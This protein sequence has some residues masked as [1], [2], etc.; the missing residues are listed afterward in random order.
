MET[1]T[2][3]GAAWIVGQSMTEIELAKALGCPVATVKR[4]RSEGRI[5]YVQIGRGRIIYLAESILRWLKSK[6]VW[7]NDGGLRG[8]APNIS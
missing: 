2:A 5:P 8:D 3:S 7:E 6:E 4:L 1:Q